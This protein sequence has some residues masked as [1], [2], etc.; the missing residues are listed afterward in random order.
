MSPKVSVCI[1]TYNYAAYLSVAIQSVLTQ[2]FTDWELI[3][4]DNC[5]TDNTA[6]VVT[7]FL[8]E[9]VRYVRNDTNLGMVGNW[10]R[11]LELAQGELIG[12][13]HA[14]DAYMPRLLEVAVVALSAHPQAGYFYSAYRFMDSDS[15]PGNIVRPFPTAHVWPGEQEFREHIRLP[16]V[17]C[18]TVIIRR[19]AIESVGPFMA[20]PELGLAN[21]WEMWLRI[22][23][24]GWQVAYAPE[25]LA[26]WRWHQGSLSREVDRRNDRIGEQARV[27]EYVMAHL[28]A[29]RL[30][31]REL[32]KPAIYAVAQRALV[33]GV[34]A[35]CQR[36]GR[37]AWLHFR[38]AL[39]TA[40]Q[41]GLAGFVAYLFRRV[42]IVA[43]RRWWPT[44]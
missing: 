31:L 11:C 32:R 18:P 12:L 27:I 1:P 41:V 37:T 14:D 26:L 6:E 23:L 9:R 36:A 10:N 29:A 13:L 39:Q 19:T 40:R 25:P 28:P 17:Q 35:V 16:Y 4:V 30:H 21:D 42:T 24:A 7:S 5:S 8:S 34:L 2:T 20:A 15:C 22:E 38:Q 44:A 43:R 33:A 3:V